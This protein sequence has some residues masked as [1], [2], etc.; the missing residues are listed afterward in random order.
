MMKLAGPLAE[1]DRWQATG[2]SI[3][4][5]MELIGTRSAV[6]ILREAFYGATRFDQF[7][8]RVG[9]TDAVA[10]ARLKELTEAGIFTKVPYREP[11]QRAR[12][13]YRLTEM[14]RDLFPVIT[15]LMQFGNDHLQPDGA[16]LALRDVESGEPVR[17]DVVAGADRHLTPEDVEVRIARPRR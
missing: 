1:R 16:P 7:A 4:K 5:A 12:S 8:R 14:G 15:A 10:A 9:I 17:V 11:G 13:E 6:L 2:C 3:A